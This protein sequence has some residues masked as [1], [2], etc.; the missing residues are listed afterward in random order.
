MPNHSELVRLSLY[1]FRTT[2]DGPK[3]I[4]HDRGGRR[5][6]ILSFAWRRTKCITS[7]ALLPVSLH[8]H[9]DAGCARWFK[10]GYISESYSTQVKMPHLCFEKYEMINCS[11]NTGLESHCAGRWGE[12][13]SNPKCILFQGTRD[14]YMLIF[15]HIRCTSV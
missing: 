14:S 15:S 11:G 9:I 13:P 12:I 2:L 8:A 6:Q 1:L 5:T 7:I 10:A 3:S 4:R